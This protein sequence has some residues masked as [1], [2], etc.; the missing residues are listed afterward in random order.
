MRPPTLI[1]MRTSSS[2]L[3]LRPPNGR[4]GFAF[5]KGRGGRRL[6]EKGFGPAGPRGWGPA[7][8]PHGDL[9]DSKIAAASLARRAL[10]SPKA[11][12]REITVAAAQISATSAKP[13][14][15]RTRKAQ[16]IRVSRR[17]MNSCIG[18]P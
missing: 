3:S 12:H 9:G 16:P 18:A 5:P 8:P 11:A 15:S 4:S 6:A 1:P 14:I 17:S 13:P 10:A 2:P 7:D